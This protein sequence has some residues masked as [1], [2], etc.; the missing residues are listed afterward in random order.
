MKSHLKYL[1][2]IIFLLIFCC[3]SFLLSYCAPQQKKAETEQKEPEVMWAGPEGLVDDIHWYGNAAIRIETGDKTIFIDPFEIPE[4][5][6]SDLVLITHPHFDH[7]SE[8]DLKKVAT[9]DTVFVTP[10]NRQCISAIEKLFD[11]EPVVLWPGEKAIAAGFKVEAVPSYNVVKKERHP[12]E[13]AYLGYIITVDDIRIYHAG[14]TELIPEM[15]SF[16]C[17]IAL[18][19]LGQIYTMNSV[20]EAA[21]AALDVKATIAIPIHYGSYEGTL[22]DAHK[23]K[24]LLEPKVHVIIKT[25][26]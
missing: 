5:Y 14:D 13:F 20:E 22:A 11:K 10:H 25:K 24:E 8:P 9:K 23:F 16:F 3:A 21:Q 1:F 2:S 7:L 18:L 15:K 12:K 6:K 4:D 17:D 19:P 26:E